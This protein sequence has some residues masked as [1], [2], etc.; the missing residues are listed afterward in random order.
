MSKPLNIA[1][2]GY[3]FMGRAHSNA[4]SKVNHFFDL[5]HR[6][7]LKAVCARSTD[8]A[9]EFADIVKIGRTHLQ[10]AVPLTVGQEFGGWA[11]LLDRDIQRI[12][13][14]L[15]GPDSSQ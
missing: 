11:S 4:Y 8:K 9:K 12:E 10:D 2:I 5:Q 6:P 13:K 1:M 7:V 3:G 14:T 15:E